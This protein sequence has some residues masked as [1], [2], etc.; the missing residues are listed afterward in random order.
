MAYMEGVKR[1]LAAAAIFLA[2]L[3]NRHS[4]SLNRIRAVWCQCLSGARLGRYGAAVRTGAGA[5]EK[6]RLGGPGRGRS[7]GLPAPRGKTGVILSTPDFQ[8]AT[9]CKSAQANSGCR[10]R[11][12]LRR[13]ARRPERAGA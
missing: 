12:R 2:A 4:A 8:L 9:V 1:N 5:K 6:P 10:H 7:W 11:L 3:A 13:G